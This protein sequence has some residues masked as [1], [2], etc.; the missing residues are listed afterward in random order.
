MASKKSD[1]DAPEIETG[2]RPIVADKGGPGIGNDRAV[3][4]TLEE[5]N[6]AGLFGNEVDGTPNSHYTLAGVVANKPT[7]ENQRRK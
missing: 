4:T 1:S 2:P 7:P 6:A 5:A 3:T